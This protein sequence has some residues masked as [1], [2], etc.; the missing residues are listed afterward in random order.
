MLALTSPI[1]TPFHRIPAWI[2]LLLLAGFTFGVFLISNPGHMSVPLLLVAGLYLIAGKSFLRSG[3]R[4]IRP[5]WIFVLVI[6]LW[7]LATRDPGKWLVLSMRLLATVSLANLITMTTRMD[8]MMDVLS[9]LMRPLERIGL[10]AGALSLSMALVVRFT[11][12]LI[13]RERQLAEAWRARSPR[14]PRWNIVVPLTLTA[15][16]DAEQVAEALKARGGVPRD[17]QS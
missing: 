11:P 15:I 9:T 6:L 3:L 16:D 5:L 17:P 12:V 14:R 2:K 13:G 8:E 4:A 7:H 1:E 10:R